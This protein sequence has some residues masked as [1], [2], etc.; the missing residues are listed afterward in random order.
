[1]KGFDARNYRVNF[2]KVKKTL[3]FEP[4]YRVADGVG[5]LIIA[6]ENKVFDAVENKS[7]I[8]GNYE[9]FY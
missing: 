2:S 5:E 7:S 6:L 9:I 4:Q 8:F 3:G 1:M